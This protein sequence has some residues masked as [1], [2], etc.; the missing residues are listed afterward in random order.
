MPHYSSWYVLGTWS[1]ED[2]DKNF[3]R[4]VYTLRIFI[5]KCFILSLS[6]SLLVQRTV[7]FFNEVAYLREKAN[8][9]EDSRKDSRKDPTSKSWGY[10]LSFLLWK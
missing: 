3:M 9:I 7:F 2:L 10:L 8:M 4:F 6:L 5:S 1:I